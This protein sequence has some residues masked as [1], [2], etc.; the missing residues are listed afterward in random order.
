MGEKE[1][2]GFWSANGA[3]RT[4]AFAGVAGG[5]EMIINMPL[6]YIKTYMQL[7][8][9]KAAS[10]ADVVRLTRADFGLRGLYRGL[11]VM[12]A[13]SIPK[14]A[15]R[16]G[17]A[18]T[19]RAR[20]KDETGKVSPIKNFGAGLLGG[21][22][23]AVLVVTPQETMKVRLIHDRL[24]PTPRFRN[25]FHGIG[26]LVKEQGISGCYKGLAATI[27]KQG[28]NQAIRFT[29]FYQVKSWLLGSPTADFDY[30]SVK[31]FGQVVVSGLIAGAASVIGNT[32]VDVIKTQMQGL[33]A[34]K[35][36]GVVDCAKHIYREG[37]ITA[38]YAGVMARMVRVSI[39]C[40]LV[41]GLFF[42]IKAAINSRF[43]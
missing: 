17:V 14:S 21:M 24:Q 36:N 35:Y 19:L 10:M 34:S 3:G 33:E 6:E 9:S 31:G 32:P 30:W 26:V 27:I 12:L 23:E 5:I 28:T 20:L 43:P 18:E 13:F 39:D 41:F 25:G 8:P 42:Y 4:V 11:D 40:S 1:S 15:V 2:K 7:Y 37:G 38:F 22:C 29:A 16:F